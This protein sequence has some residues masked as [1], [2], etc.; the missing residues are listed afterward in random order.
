MSA[1][2]GLAV[3]MEMRNATACPGTCPEIEFWHSKNARKLNEISILQRPDFTVNPQV[4]GS[5]PVE[6]VNCCKLI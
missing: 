2:E 4:P 5:S 1:L 6:S 3:V